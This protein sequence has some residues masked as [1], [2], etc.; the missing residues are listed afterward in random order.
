MA[1]DECSRRRRED[2]RQLSLSDE[3][4]NLEQRLEHLSLNAIEQL[5]AKEFAALVEE[6][7]ARL[8]VPERAVLVLFHQQERTY[9]QIAE[10]LTIPPQHRTDAPASRTHQAAQRARG[11][12]CYSI[13]QGDSMKQL[14]IM[15]PQ[16]DLAK[17]LTETLSNLAPFDVPAGFASRVVAAANRL[18]AV[19]TRRQQAR[20]RYAAPLIRVA[21]G[22]LILAM[23]LLASWAASAA[24]SLYPAVAEGLLAMEFV[25]LVLWFSLRPLRERT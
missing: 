9:E 17:R 13:Q 16:D 20:V 24:G 4:L 19:N 5:E 2:R 23:F 15:E 8:S 21:L 18:P 7:L 25:L 6:H 1:H 12:G 14:P 10:L 3:D 22:L 11:V